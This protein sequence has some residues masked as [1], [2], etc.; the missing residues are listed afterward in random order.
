[1]EQAGAA[2]IIA[3][4][5]RGWETVLSPHFAGGVDLSGGQW[6]RVAL[7]RALYA[8]SAGARVLVLDGGRI[9]ELGTH[10]QLLAAGATYAHMFR[11]QAE[12]FADT[13]NGAQSEA[14]A[15]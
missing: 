14:D 6:Q 2:D 13:S 1:A 5:P 11:L 4:L 7:A 9:T 15:R 12:R 10:E 3:S 8:V